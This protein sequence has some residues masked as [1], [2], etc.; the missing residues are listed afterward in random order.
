MRSPS[1]E[2]TWNF[3]EGSGQIL[4]MPGNREA[5][6]CLE[7]EEKEERGRERLKRPQQA[8]AALPA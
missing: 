4:I 7:D 6:G 3:V 8:A 5:D 2:L 1:L